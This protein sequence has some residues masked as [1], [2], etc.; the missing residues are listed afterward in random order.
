MEAEYPKTNS[1]NGNKGVD[2][3]NTAVTTSQFTLKGDEVC[4]LTNTYP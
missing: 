3:T 1:R 4:M 2:Q